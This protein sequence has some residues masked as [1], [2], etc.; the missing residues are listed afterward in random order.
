M[1]CK[2]FWLQKL[3]EQRRHRRRGVGIKHHHAQYGATWVRASSRVGILLFPS[4]VSSTTRTHTLG[5]GF[6]GELDGNSSAKFA[7]PSLEQL[8]LRVSDSPA[9]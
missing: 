4:F 6:T 2:S 3:Q 5:S 7:Q 9:E 8:W 1:R